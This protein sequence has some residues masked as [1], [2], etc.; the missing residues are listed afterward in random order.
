MIKSPSVYKAVDKNNTPLYIG[1]SHDVENRLLQHWI[2]EKWWRENVKQVFVATCNSY[3]DMCIYELYY[4]TKYK[5]IYNI[6]SVYLD[7]GP[8]IY[9]PELEFKLYSMYKT[10]WSNLY[11]SSDFKDKI[12]R[13]KEY[14]VNSDYTYLWDDLRDES[15]DIKAFSQKLGDYISNKLIFTWNYNLKSANEINDIDRERAAISFMESIK[16]RGGCDRYGNIINDLITYYGSEDA[17]VQDI[18]KKIDYTLPRA[19][20]KKA[21]SKYDCAPSHIPFQDGEMGLFYQIK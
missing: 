15:T 4:I 5:P 6:D 2:D 11:P 10:E 14:A 12:S 21:L 1:R 7:E 18:A 8:T 13:K 16:T 9:L 3:S 20:K 17:L 19:Y